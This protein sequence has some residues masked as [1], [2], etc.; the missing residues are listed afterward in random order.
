[1]CN[2]EELNVGCI[3]VEAWP[4]ME[5]TIIITGSGGDVKICGKYYIVDDM[6]GAAV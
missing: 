1:M 2:Q 4:P 5:N 6:N 3:D